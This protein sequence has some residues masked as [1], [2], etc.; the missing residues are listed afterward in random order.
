MSKIIIYFPDTGDYNFTPPYELLMQAKALENTGIITILADHRTDDIYRILE[1]NHTE[2]FLFVI[3]TIS[4][5]T[6]ITIAKQ[7]VDGKKISDL[8]K[9][10]YN[11]PVLWTGQAAN[12]L[13]TGI[14]NVAYSD[15][16]LKGTSEMHLKTFVEKI[17][18]SSPLN[19]IKGLCYSQNDKIIENEAADIE[20]SFE[21]F[22]D[23]DLQL[24]QMAKYIRSN[25]FDYVATTGCINSCSFC[26]VPVIYKRKWFHNSTEN[27]KKHLSFIIGKYSHIKNIHFRD[28][29]FLVNK[30]F[31]FRLFD[32][33][34]KSGLSF[35]WSAQTSVNVLN[36]YSEDDLK[37]LRS[38]GCN[39]ISVGIESGDQYILKKVTKSKTDLKKGA[40]IIRK[41]LNC[42]ITASV[43]SIISFP[44]NKGRDFD[45]TLRYLMKLKL[46][47]PGLSMYCTI[48]QP[49]P[50]TEI[51]NEICAQEIDYTNLLTNNS[52][53]DEKKRKKLKKFENFY[54]VFDDKGFYKKL[55]EEVGKKIKI[56]NKLFS[57]ILKL[58]FRFGCTSFLWEYAL[59]ARKLNKIKKEYGITEDFQ[60]SQVGIRHLTSNFGFGYKK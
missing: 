35:L 54:F 40:D 49:I 26:S 60:M 47:Y 25:L 20:N 7:F 42:D 22:G 58:R 55:P 29:N 41:L 14:I 53:T 38:F 8:V 17:F 57:P 28:D 43:T 4:K 44:Y 16:V 5:Y 6:S 59:I 10:K 13:F 21:S 11:I 2:T 23:F 19:D 3:S 50:G 18:T 1:E 52:W 27:I 32:E 36:K 45:K 30:K 24:I 9:K 51:F 12:L 34:E 15:F 39:N 56:I 31:I 48:F 37:K 33:L 46:L